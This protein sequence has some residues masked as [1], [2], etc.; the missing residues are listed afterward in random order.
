[1]PQLTGEI[2]ALS[3]CLKILMGIGICVNLF[4]YF[5]IL[6][7]LKCIYYASSF[8]NLKVSVKYL[9]TLQQDQHLFHILLYDSN[10]ACQDV[11]F[12]LNRFY[13]ILCNK[14]M[15]TQSPTYGREKRKTPYNCQKL[16]QIK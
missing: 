2:P 12:S 14:F 8:K 5:F 9:N 7:I 6:I 10:H 16:K 3:W 15:R 13:L 1:M 4:V 11:S